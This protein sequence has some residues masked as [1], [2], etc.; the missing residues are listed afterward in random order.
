MNMNKVSVKNKL[1]S[2]QADLNLLKKA[3]STRP[4]F[5]VDEQN[6]RKLKSASKKARK[7]IFKKTY[8]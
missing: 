3:L 7:K 2:L 4:D 6:W 8:G 1:I 5:N